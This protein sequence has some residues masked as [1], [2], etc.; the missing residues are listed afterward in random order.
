MEKLTINYVNRLKDAGKIDDSQYFS[1][2][3]RIE[4]EWWSNPKNVILNIL[5]LGCHGLRHVGLL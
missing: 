4:S 5:T 3:M 2:R 1:L